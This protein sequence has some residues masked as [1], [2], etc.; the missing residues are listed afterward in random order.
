MSNENLIMEDAELKP[1]YSYSQIFKAI[2]KMTK[3]EVDSIFSNISFNEL[4]ILLQQDGGAE[5]YIQH[6]LN[7]V[8]DVIAKTDAIAKLANL[9][10]TP[11]DDSEE[12]ENKY[13][14]MDDD[15]KKATA[16]RLLNNPDFQKDCTEI[17]YLDF[18]KI[19]DSNSSFKALDSLLG[20]SK[21]YKQNIERGIG[22]NHKYEVE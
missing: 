2:E 7:H 13:S 22:L 14:S 5:Y 4:I 8:S 10:K 15:E 6:L 19:I 16:L 11:C 9:L 3:E 17:M 20:I 1:K 18:K 21:W 12:I